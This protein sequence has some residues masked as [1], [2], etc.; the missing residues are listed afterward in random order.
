MPSELINGRSF[1]LSRPLAF[2]M[3]LTVIYT[4]GLSILAAHAATG[5]P[6]RSS[7]L[8]TVTFSLI[9]TWW[10]YADRDT[11]QFK[12]PYQFEYFVLIAWPILVPYYLYRRL[13]RRG[14]LVALGILCLYLLPSFIAAFIYAFEQVGALHKTR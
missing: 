10:V 2:L 5:P 3:V 9:L 12:L 14:L 4:I 8:W 13:G 7:G 1:P 11:R 6:D